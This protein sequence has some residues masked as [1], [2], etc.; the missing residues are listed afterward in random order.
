MFFPDTDLV[1]V[2][3][4]LC[5]PFSLPNRSIDKKTDQC[6]TW[7]SGVVAFWSSVWTERRSCFVGPFKVRVLI[8]Y[9]S[10]QTRLK[11]ASARSCKQK[12]VHPC[13]PILQCLRDLHNSPF[14]VE[15]RHC[16]AIAFTRDRDDL[17]IST[18]EKRWARSVNSLKER[19]PVFNSKVVIV[20][21]WKRDQSETGNCMVANIAGKFKNWSSYF[22]NMYGQ[23]LKF[24]W[25]DP[26]VTKIWSS[27][28]SW[29]GFRTVKSGKRGLSQLYTFN[30]WDPL[31]KK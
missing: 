13:K 25:N 5:K 18:H 4:F 21:H 17:R 15:D 29:L 3:L 24:V 7:F 22:N 10:T 20:R 9:I 12:Q 14:L 2:K 6:M 1:L 16:L 31:Q 30:F 8:V 11:V 23:R 19:L 26:C 27:R 28:L